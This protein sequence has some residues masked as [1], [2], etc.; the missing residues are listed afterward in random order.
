MPNFGEAA[1]KWQEQNAGRAHP[2]P[3]TLPPSGRPKLR[4]KFHENR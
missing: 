4:E 3:L 1:A 2:L